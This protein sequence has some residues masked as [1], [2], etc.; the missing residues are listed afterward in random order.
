ML[1]VNELNLDY[2]G[3]F[4]SLPGDLLAYT[5]LQ[6]IRKQFPIHHALS[7]YFSRCQLTASK[8]TDIVLKLSSCAIA[9]C[10]A[11]VSSLVHVVCMM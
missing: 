3:R 1:D 4:D 5:Q 10:L 7:K 6:F 11:Y 9:H 8:F 2:T